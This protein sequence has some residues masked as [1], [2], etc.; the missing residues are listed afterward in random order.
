MRSTNFGN[1]IL[2]SSPSFCKNSKN[3]F[4]AFF[5][6]ALNFSVI[7]WLHHPWVCCQK[8]WIESSSGSW[9]DLAWRTVHWSF[10]NFSFD[11]SE[12]NVSHGFVTE[13]SLPSTPSE[14]LDNTLSDSIQSILISSAD[15][16]IIDQSISA[17]MFRSKRP[18]MIG[19]KFIPII[20]SFKKRW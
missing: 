17:V 7:D 5:C 16:R 8:C 6:C 2:N 13:R 19:S 1:V 4:Y 11:H 15:Q 3:C 20:L 12:F 9:N 14:S 10:T 18:Y